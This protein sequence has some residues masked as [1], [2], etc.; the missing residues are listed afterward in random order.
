MTISLNQSLIEPTRCRQAMKV[1]RSAFE[2]DGLKQ[3]SSSPLAL[4]A[5]FPVRARSLL[6]CSYRNS[7]P[8]HASAGFLETA[9]HFKVVPVIKLFSVGNSFS[10]LSLT[11]KARSDIHGVCDVLGA[12]NILL[13]ALFHFYLLFRL[14]MI[15]IVLHNQSKSRSFS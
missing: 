6:D 3:Q 10:C 9:L 13:T 11:V 8:F 5:S 2:T 1:S 7:L 15:D 14:L 4:S 12:K